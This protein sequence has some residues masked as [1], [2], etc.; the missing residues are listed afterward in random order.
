MT[1]LFYALSFLDSRRN[2]LSDDPLDS[3]SDADW[4]TIEAMVANAY[5]VLS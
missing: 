2:W 3:I 4:D 5:G 1:V